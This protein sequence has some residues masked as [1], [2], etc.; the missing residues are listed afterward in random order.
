MMKKAGFT[1]VVALLVTAGVASAVSSAGGGGALL[2]G[3]ESHVRQASFLG[4]YDG[5]KD[6]YLITDVSSKSQAKALH[7]NYSAALADVKNIPAQYFIQ[8]R[9]ARGQIA[10]FGSEPGESDYNPLW[11]ELFVTWKSGVKPVVLTSDNQILAAQKAGKLTLR[12]SKIVLNA[13]IVKVGK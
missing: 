13:P 4:Y 7:V 2:L 6:T 9:S 10:V 1:V 3:R 11:V 8:G 5:H 12:T